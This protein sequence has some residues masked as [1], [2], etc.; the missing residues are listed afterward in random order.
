VTTVLKPGWKP[1][2]LTH[3]QDAAERRERRV[4][5]QRA[6]AESMLTEYGVALHHCPTCHSNLGY[7]PVTGGQS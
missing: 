5:H 2:G 1:T 7:R 4:E 6:I 3:K